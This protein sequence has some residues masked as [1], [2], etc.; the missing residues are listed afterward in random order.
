VRR[1]WPHV[2][3]SLALAL[4]L[5]ASALGAGTA[6]DAQPGDEPPRARTPGRPGLWRRI[7]DPN[8]DEV[9]TL[10]AKARAS[11]LRADE[12]RNG[13]EEWALEQRA[14]FYRDAYNLLA[15]ARKRA[16]ENV[17][18][19]A[20][21]ARAAEELGRTAEAIE[22][23]ERA[24]KLTSPERAPIE[25]VARLGALHLR[26]GDTERALRWLRLAQG[27]VPLHG[28]ALEQAYAVI[29]YATVLAARGDVA[30]AIHAIAAALPERSRS[31]VSHE[32]TI[33]TFALAV[34]FDRD[35][36]RAAAFE[37]LE[38]MQSTLGAQYRP[39]IQLELA[40]MRFLPPEDLHYYRALLYESFNQYAEARAE[41]ALYAAAGP[42]TY[43]G[44]ALD[45]IQAIDAQRRATAGAK[46]PQQPAPAS[47]IP[48]RLPVP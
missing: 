29:H 28:N 23:L 24:A 18:A 43:R 14:R 1:R 30:A 11:M 4:A 20:A 9:R 8:G 15:Y 44:R 25:V 39:Q 10:V 40:R 7:V 2:S 33:L 37:V 45:H 32:T 26:A 27:P 5:A 35:E 19:L 13:D 22:A 34:L 16:P 21:F 17:D 41:W 36:Q 38:H 31:Q 47:A 48:R 3:I 46:P 12:A 6:A 42:P